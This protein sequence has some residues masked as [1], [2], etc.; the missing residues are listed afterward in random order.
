MEMKKYQT[1]EMEVVE[2]KVQQ[3]LLTLSNGEAPNAN[4]PLDP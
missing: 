2:V 1:P 3:T 4:D